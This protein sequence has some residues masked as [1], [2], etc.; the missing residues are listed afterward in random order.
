MTCTQQNN[1]RNWR[2]WISITVLVELLLLAVS[3]GG[4]EKAPPTITGSNPPS[5]V[6]AAGDCIPIQ[7]EFAMNGHVIQG[8]RWNVKTGEGRILGNGDCLITYQAPAD[9]GLYELSV[10][11]E[12]SGNESV[13]H[14]VKVRVVDVTPVSTTAAPSTTPKLTATPA[15]TSTD[16]PALTPTATRVLSPAPTFTPIP[17]STL[18]GTPT[19]V[20]SSTNTPRPVTYT[21]SNTPT[22]NYGP[23]V[24]KKV[25]IN[26]CNVTF[27][28]GW[29][30]TLKEYEW[31]AVRVGVGTPKSKAWVKQSPYTYTLYGDTDQYNWEIAICQGE[32]EEGKC[33]QL[34]VSDRG[35]FSFAGCKP[36]P[37]RPAPE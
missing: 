36:P 14:S 13:K 21:P 18:T 31:F 19:A 29:S 35:S 34:V 25:E 28:W 37:T 17:A 16:T 9:P 30:G 4:N 24:L 6:V 3:C 32:P 20:S 1:C 7:V 11:L 26:S 15:S 27:Q 23:L 10:E 8:C 33:E 12:Y 2:I 22:S 5:P